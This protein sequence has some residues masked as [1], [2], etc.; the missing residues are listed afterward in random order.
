MR[1]FLLAVSAV[2]SLVFTVLQPM[3][4]ATSA[5]T[6]N[7]T[8][9]VTK[10]DGTPYAGVSVALLGWDDA[11]Q[12]DFLSPIS[13]TD[14][15]GVA[16]VAVSSTA[17]FYGYGAQPPAN[18]FSHANFIEYS[19]GY[20]QSESY[21]IRMRPASLVVELK[22]T[23]G[24]S[25]A[26]G[27]WVHFP[28]TGDVGDN[29][30]ARPVLRSGPIGLDVS[31]GLAVGETYKVK[32]QP[33]AVAGQFW[34]EYA[35]KV[36]DSYA[37]SLFPN[38]AS[39]TALTPRVVNSTSIY[40]L[41]FSP[42]N[43]RGKLTTAQGGTLTVPAGVTARVSFNKAD[44]AGNLDPESWASADSI[45]SANGSFEAR[46]TKPDSGKYFPIFTVAGSLS[47]PSFT[48]APFFVDSNGYYSNSN[49]GPFVAPESFDLVRALPAAA[50][51]NLKFKVLQPNS[52]LLDDAYIQ[53]MREFET[54]SSMYVGAGRASNG[55]A[56]FS[57]ADGVY[58]VFLDFTNPER[59]RKEYNLVVD[60]GEP[61]LTLRGG[62]VVAANGD[63][64]YELSGG[65]P[66]L[67]IRVL[68]PDD[69]T[70]SLPQVSVDIFNPALDGDNYVVGTWAQSGLAYL[71]V[72]NGTY[73]LRLHPQTGG[74]AERSFNLVVAGTSVTI[75]DTVTQQ[76]YVAADGVFS[77]APHTPNIK[78]RIVNSA[79]QPVG[80]AGNA[81]VNVQLQKWNADN[82]RWNWVNNGNAQVM[83]DGTFGLRALEVGTYRLQVRTNGRVDVANAASSQ[84]TITDLTSLSNRGDI[85][86]PAPVL[87][88]RVTQ[89]GRAALL[90]NAGVQ[91]SDRNG[92]DDY[93]DTGSLGIAPI[94]F[95]S[96]GTY[97]LTVRPPYGLSSGVAANKT[98][99]AVV[100]GTAGSLSATITGVTATDG[101]NNLSLGIPNVTGR[102]VSPGGASI[103]RGNNVW[104]SIQ[105]QL[106]VAQENRW[107][108][109]DYWTEMA[110]DG[111]FGFGLEQN[112]TYRLRIEPN[113]VAGS[114][115]TRT[116]EFTVTDANRA[117]IAR[118][119]GDIRLAA[120]SAK[121]KVRIPG[122]TTDIKY[123]GIEIRKDDQWYDWINTDNNGI[124]NF[125]ALEA[126]SYEFTVN[127]NGDSSVSGIRK[128]YS[129]TVAE[130]A[131]SSGVFTVTVAGVA[132]DSNG[133][134]VL[135]LGVPNITGKLVDQTGAN[136]TQQNGAW[137]NIQ[138]QKYNTAGGYWDWQNNVTNVRNDGTFGLNVAEAGTYRLLINP[139]GRTDIART[140]TSQFV[141]TSA[142]A[143][144]FTKAFGNIF[145]N[146]PS[147][148]G[149]VSTPDGEI[150][151]SN[152]QVVAIS[153]ETGQEMWE[154]SSQTDS[155][156]RWAMVLPEGSYSVYARA[157]WGNQTYGNGD[158]VTG[159]TVAENGTAT[160]T[161]GSASAIGLRVANPTWSGTV[162]APGTMNPL[163]FTSICL[164]QETTGKGMGQCTE[165]DSQGRWAMSKPAGFTG[166][167]ETVR[168]TIR[169][170]RLPEYAEAQ[171]IGKTAVEAKLGA[172]VAGETY[173]NKTLSPAAPNTT[174]TI[175]AGGSAAANIWVNIERDD[176]GWLT[177][178]M[179]NAQGVVRL[180]ITN[181]SLGFKIRADA[182][183]NRLLAETYTTTVKVVSP[184]LVTTNTANGV[185]SDTVALALPNFSGTVMSPG[186]SPVAVKD[187]WVDA[188]NMTNNQWAGGSNSQVNGNVALRLDSPSVGSSYRYQVRVN[189]PWG[190]PDLWASR[191]YIVDVDSAGAMVVHA[192]TEAGAVL[193]TPS[194]AE[195]YVLSLKAP[196]VTGAVQLPDTT[197]IRD[198]W[199]EVRK[200]MQ[201][202]QQ[203]VDGIQSRANGEFGL[204]LED[205]NYEL[206]A[207]VP[208]NQSGYAKS[209]GCDVTVS[210]GVMTN[211]ASA[212]VVNGKVKL[213][214]RAPNFKVKLVHAGQAVANA[215]LNI[216]IGN[217]NTWAQAGRDGVVSLFI[218]DEEVLA[219]NSGA[220]N[221][222]QLGVRITVDPPYGNN[223]IVRWDCNAGESKP[224]CDQLTPY[225]VGTPY[226]NGSSRTL[227]DVTFAVPNTSLNVKLGDGT[228]SA[229]QG[230]WAVILVE[231][232]GWKRWLTGSNTNSEGRA[233]FN[234]DESLKN[235]SSARFTV[236]VNPAHQ[237]RG[238]YSQKSYSGLTWAQVNAQNFALG[239]PNLKLTVKQALSTEASSYG[240]VGLEEVDANLNWLSWL[241]GFGLDQQGQ[242]SLTLPSSKKVRVTFN[243]GP[244]SNGARTFCVFDVD[245][246]GVVTK[247]ATAGHC[248]SGGSNIVNSVSK[249]IQLELSAGNQTGY[250]YKASTTEAIAGAI[251][252]AQAYLVSNGSIVEGK[253]EQ[254][255]SRSDG[256]YG[257]QLDPTY[258]WKIKVFFVNPDG[259][260]TNYDSLLTEQTVS[261]AELGSPRTQNF[262][263]AVRG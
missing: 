136:V 192:D 200:Y 129:A 88:V 157:P 155:Q 57:L 127:P 70:A 231:E 216:S 234:I 8:F 190:N 21:S 135:N 193:P 150:R 86:L 47:I 78:G 64:I 207:N 217:W 37:I 121:F 51:I 18:D 132:A 82:N 71:S 138:V 44:S 202:W 118:A 194:G 95:P 248:P 29:L 213:A 188:Y 3:G 9:T 93:V 165:S 2:V 99:V 23:S 219:K 162:V 241:G 65:I 43:I 186:S 164:F 116:A 249:A 104:I 191:I 40:D 255:V 11:Q 223:D 178:G 140:V 103:V 159:V 87:K 197:P 48:G 228:T 50:N 130:T 102:I 55:L 63:G 259:A 245:S 210:G 225:V 112:G 52:S 142:N 91:I 79:N 133:F 196:S 195:R 125:S 119:F 5:T 115:I 105:A 72:P 182:Q 141:I 128:T 146:G 61:S 187:A 38:A 74:F 134:T 147:I 166:F 198:S 33:T 143:S 174:L 81:W 235:S 253:T 42:S 28:G 230:A 106:Y 218:D 246:S 14:S 109:T 96:A 262:S 161:S 108:W 203:W 117:S 205:G 31:T 16:V 69:L 149:T 4:P 233:V 172:Y 32:T 214:L 89:S 49:T 239:T 107:E 26:P 97:Y 160:I 222:Q 84:F 80:S 41:S 98:Y 92:Y 189:A 170:N 226:I 27:S 56:S 175:T 6:V 53:V 46:I 83:N 145:L 158:P 10:S 204:A 181:P 94:S 173:P 13:T 251:V 244:G 39:T 20:G 163:A 257:L 238:T 221:G 256:R 75:T 179:T 1:K 185:Y 183:S 35:L 247:S 227:N 242:V 68:N 36:S 212:C 131:P 152:S 111:S 151:L 148:A 208:W 67:K 113:G 169:E 17:D 215:N 90:N 206:T 22:T 76:S 153:D 209:A 30:S 144:T 176:V 177:S 126:G 250:I 15:S 252:Y 201:G 237:Q 66:N 154:F 100:T 167:N 85:T 171:F 25:A 7:K 24:Q 110:A 180:N 240:W 59:T 184:S 236:E 258:N 19:V 77:L 101:F 137:V 168:L 122:S 45:I 156:G 211:S 124:A 263:L 224:L 62:A 220:S 139:Y 254:S 114:A 120:P 229:G 60:Q 199:V 232:N 58:R 54:G 260:T 243:P 73:E 123:A 261:G 34:N 12:Q